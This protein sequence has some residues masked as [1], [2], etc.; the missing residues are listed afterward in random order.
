MSA[1]PLILEGFARPPRPLGVL[2]L[3]VLAGF[4]LLER[5]QDAMA[6]AV[7][8][9]CLYK[10][11]LILWLPLLLLLRGKKLALAAMAGTGVISTTR[12]IIPSTAARP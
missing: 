7:W 9:L 10:F 5:E 11:N 8:A 6:G 3:L 1:R 4:L 12:I 2:A